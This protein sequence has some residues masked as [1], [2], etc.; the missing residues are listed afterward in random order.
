MLLI[1]ASA[2][3]NRLRY[4]ADL[5]LKELLG[6]DVL[7]STSSAEFISYEGPKLCYAAEPLAD[8]PY[9]EASTLLFETNIDLH[10]VPSFVIDGVPALFKSADPRSGLPF[11]P[12]AA[13]FYMVSRYEEYHAHHKDS[14]GRYPVTES[15]AWKGKFLDNPVVNLWAGLLKQMLVRHFPSINFKPPHYRFTPTI[16]IDHAWCYKGRTVARS[17]GGLGRSL[18][19]GRLH[20]IAERIKVVAGMAP[21]P[22]DNYAF[23]HTVHAVHANFPLYFILF[24][25][26]G[27]NDNNVTIT[28]KAFHRLL[29]E[30]DRYAGV[31]IHPSLSSNKHL[32]KLENEY[33]GLSDVLDRKV[34]V[35][36]QHFLKLSMPETY[37]SLAQLGIT[38]D[39]S[40]GYAT[41]TGFRAGTANPF[42]FFDLLRNEATKLIIHPVSLMDVTL[43]D[44]LRLNKVESLEKI[45]S[46]IQTIRTVN[47]EFV[48]LWH[49]ESLGNSG[50]WKGWR[51]VYAEMVKLAS[52]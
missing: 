7:Y 9:I 18:L 28:S 19:H 6:I 5:M 23:I 30:L 2:V 27:L 20:E 43:K 26:Y 3:T 32:L 31:G 15:V 49:N 14:F 21:D 8:G 17:L 11:D 52:T 25:D 24:A 33:Y 38:N 34:T 48:S 41:H 50:R 45:N 4:M 13:S 16:D 36:R 40:M 1:F 51:E 10:D 22:Y 39:Y 35:S 37:R 42:P 44:Y 12:F 46:V 29:R 47:G